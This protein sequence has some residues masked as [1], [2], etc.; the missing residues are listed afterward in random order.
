MA[1]ARSVTISATIALTC[2]VLGGIL[3]LGVVA[4]APRLRRLDLAIYGVASRAV[5]AE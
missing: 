1:A 4:S 2:V 5:P 3:T